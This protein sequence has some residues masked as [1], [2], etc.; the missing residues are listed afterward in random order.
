MKKETASDR[1]RIL[2][3]TRKKAAALSASSGLPQYLMYDYGL[4]LLVQYARKN[5]LSPIEGVKH[6]D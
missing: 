6:G 4:D 5:R 1:A 3:K 2:P